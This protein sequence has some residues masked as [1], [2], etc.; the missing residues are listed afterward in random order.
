MQSQEMLQLPPRPHKVDADVG[1]AFAA[2]ALLS[3]A[4]RDPLFQSMRLR[5]LEDPKDASS[6]CPVQ[7]L[8]C[9]GHPSRTLPCTFHSIRAKSP[10]CALRSGA[11]SCAAAAAAAY[12]AC[13]AFSQVMLSQYGNNGRT[14]IYL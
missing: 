7:P 9:G 8:T 11:I 4:E 6:A 5:F 3:A 12:S 13:F 10:I 1:S 2:A 14:N